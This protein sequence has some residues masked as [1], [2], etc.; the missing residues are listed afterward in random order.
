MSLKLLISTDNMKE[1]R[2][3]AADIPASRI[4]PYIQEAQQFDLKRLLGDPFYLDFLLRFDNSADGKY[5]DY[6]L[7]LLGT[8]YTYNGQTYE[9]PGLLGYLS[10]M[11]LARFFRNNSINATKYGLVQK[12]V[13][14]SEPIDWRALEGAV[15]ELRANAINLQVDILQYLRAHQADKFPLFAMADPSVQ[16]DTSVK[17]IDLD[18]PSPGINTN[19]NK[20]SSL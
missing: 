7:L 18:D 16:D 14:Q 17:F 4:L 20:F 9:H 13:E 10:Y 12:R 19:R 2:P 11:T 1:F 3:L 15:Q 5:A 6:Q 8:S